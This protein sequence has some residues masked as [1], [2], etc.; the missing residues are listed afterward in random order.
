MKRL[1]AALTAPQRAVLE[2]L[3]RLSASP[4]YLVGGAVRDFLLARPVLDLDFAIEG[5]ADDLAR[6]LADERGVGVKLHERF[7]TAKVVLPDGME[8]DIA[9]TRTEKYPEAA[10]LPVVQ[11]GAT[12]EEDLVRRDFT[13]QAM[14]M[15]L[16]GD[17][18]GRLIDPFDGRG[19]LQKK[20]IRILHPA[21]FRDDPVRAFRAVRYACRLGFR[22]ETDTRRALTNLLAHPEWLEAGA[23]R[24]LDEWRRSFEEMRWVSIQRALVVENLLGWIGI[25][26]I[27]R[28][29]RLR[30]V[31]GLLRRA[32]LDT[33]IRLWILRW[34]ALLSC[35]PTAARERIVGRLPFERAVKKIFSAPV[36]PGTLLKSLERPLAPSRVVR[37][38]RALP[39]EWLLAISIH[40]GPLG[41]R[42]IGRFI[43]TWRH[44]ASP[45]TGD[46]LKGMG[47]R[48]GP[49]YPRL[50]QKLRDAKLDGELRSSED[51]ERIVSRARSMK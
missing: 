22:I 15:R 39:L 38:L 37:L 25:R 4:L 46:D 42:H 43:K 16:N 11:T 14:A 44:V 13:I 8:V 29:E 2:D 36:R 6:K 30:L 27:R 41:R 19:D 7:S 34:I 1:A 23:D 48:P 9:R 35:C 12:I 50:L 3:C 10:R 40:A 49:A 21:S 18:A 5:C 24:I 33:A 51:I 31:D 45:L 32:P 20:L 28:A 17:D 47:V 26:M